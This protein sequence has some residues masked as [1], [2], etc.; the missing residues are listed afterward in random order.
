M[1]GDE[2]GGLGGGRAENPRRSNDRKGQGVLHASSPRF[3][4]GYPNGGGVAAMAVENVDGGIVE[5]VAFDRISFTGV[6][7]PIF[8]RG[9]SRSGRPCGTP[10]N[11]KYVFRN[12][13][14]ENV[15]GDC[16]G[17]LPSAI[18]G[19]DA[20]RIHNVTLRNVSVLCRGADRDASLRAKIDPVP[21]KPRGYPCLLQSFS[22]HILPAFGL[23]VDRVDDI[24]LDNVRFQLRAESPDARPAVAWGDVTGRV[25]LELWDPEKC[26]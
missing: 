7:A 25:G 12:I 26:L 20:C 2:Y 15:E 22:P 13:S 21:Y 4:P 1:L 24:R 16:A 9:G 23:Y 19:V 14:I 11:D 5:D 6:H 17:K 10:A 18:T 3:L 8:I